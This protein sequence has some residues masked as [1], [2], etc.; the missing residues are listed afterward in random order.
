MEPGDLFALATIV[1]ATLV[2]LYTRRKDKISI[3]ESS[4]EYLQR[5][6]EK[7]LESDANLIAAFKTVSSKEEISVDNARLVYFHFMRINRIFRVYEYMR[8]GF[9]GRK[10][11]LR[12]ID[13]Y[14]PL[15]KEAE[16]LLPQLTKR[17]Y[18]PDFEDFVIDRVKPVKA[19]EPLNL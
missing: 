4:F 14:L 7:A 16:P 19:R 15:I 9:L 1:I 3:L 8:K 10:E 11:A 17:G 13:S 12:V 2:F 5:I 18:P 6:N